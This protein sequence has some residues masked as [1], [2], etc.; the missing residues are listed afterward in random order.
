MGLEQIINLSISRETASISQAGFGTPLILG[1][2]KTASGIGS[3]SSLTEVLA[4]PGLTSGTDEYKAAAKLLAQSPAPST[5]KIG[6]ALAKVAQVDTLTPVVANSS[7]YI[8]GI[9]GAKNGV[10]FSLSYD[11]TSS[12]SATATN[13]TTGV[14]ALINA[15]SANNGV[16]ATGSTTSIITASVP[17]QPFTVTVTAAFTQVHTTAN[18]GVVDSLTALSLVDDDWYALVSTFRSIDDVVLLAAYIEGVFK[19][20]GVSSSA[21]GIYD[22]AST[23]DIGYLLKASAYFRTFVMFSED[24]ANFPEAALMGRFLPLTPGTEQWSFKTLAGVAVINPST[25]KVNAMKTKNV[26]FCQVMAGKNISR[27]GKVA[28]GEFIDVIR[29]IDLLRARMMEEIF[30]SLFRA[31]K[32]PMTNGGITVVENDVQGVLT[33]NQKIGGIAPD[34]V[35]ADTGDLI[36]G[37]ET[38]FPKI[39][40]V[41]ANDRAARILSGGTWSAK[42]A[43]AIIAVDINGTVTV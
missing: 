7:H 6:K 10:P 33:A 19:I 27:E 24:V 13:I 18:V 21:V 20:F 39:S 38:D 42:I 26:N 36:P 35:D 1:S 25:T 4:E 31:D 40:E 32:I 5:V 16:A 17:G 30:G 22:A 14:N 12:G 15:D 23:T 41:D 2:N 37:F 9:V 43:G 11:F 28:G 8:V 3:Y 34:D 29:L